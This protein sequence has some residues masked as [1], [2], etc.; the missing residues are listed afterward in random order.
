MTD[1]IVII[2]TFLIIGYKVDVAFF[3]L[4]LLMLIREYS[5]D[6]MRALAAARQV[7][8]SADA[9][10]KFK[11]VLFMTTM[12]GA[13]GNHAVLGSAAFQQAMVLLAVGG[14]ILA[15]LTLGRFYLKCKAL[16]VI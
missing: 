14:M 4:G 7:V 16:Q 3:Y 1:K 8:I 2:T 10:S 9:F 15:Y 5:I 13:I 12:L 11:G 6:T